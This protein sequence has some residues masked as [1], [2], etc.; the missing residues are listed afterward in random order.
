MPQILSYGAASTIVLLPVSSNLFIRAVFC[1]N[2]KRL[3]SSTISNL[4]V[5]NTAGQSGSFGSNNQRYYSVR[6]NNAETPLTLTMV[7][8]NKIASN[9]G[10][11]R[12]NPGDLVSVA[13]VPLGQTLP[14]AS[15]S[16]TYTI[17]S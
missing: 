12:V 11:I 15:G 16:V 7:G 8:D 3:P 1:E 17:T 4:Y 13:Y 14:P 5:V 2:F 10:S 6:V 9:A